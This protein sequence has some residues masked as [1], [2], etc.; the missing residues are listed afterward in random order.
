VKFVGVAASVFF[1]AAAPVILGVTQALAT[2]GAGAISHNS[3]EEID[4][5]KL[6]ELAQDGASE[7]Q[8]RKNSAKAL[9]EVWGKAKE[10]WKKITNS[11][12]A[13]WDEVADGEFSGENVKAFSQSSSGFISSV[14]ELLKG[15]GSP[16]GPQTVQIPEF[17][18]SDGRLS[19]IISNLTALRAEEATLRTNLAVLA[20]ELQQLQDQLITQTA[21]VS[22]LQKL[23]LKNNVDL[24]KLRQIS[25]DLRR[26]FL[27]S[28]ARTASLVLRGNVYHTGRHLEV[29]IG[30]LTFAGDQ[31]TRLQGELDMTDPHVLRNDLAAW[32]AEAW[33]NYSTLALSAEEALRAWSAA[34]GGATPTVYTYTADLDSASSSDY[35]RDGRDFL[36][37]IN[38]VLRESFNAENDEVKS[39]LARVPIRIPWEKSRVSNFI[40]PE[41]LLG[42]VVTRVEFDVPIDTSSGRQ[43][44]IFV[45]HPRNGELTYSS[46]GESCSLAQDYASNGTS[47]TFSASAPVD[48]DTP[49]NELEKLQTINAFTELKN[50]S[51]PIRASYYLTIDLPEPEAWEEAPIVRRMNISF[52]GIRKQ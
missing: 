50:R 39:G 18:A 8:K 35:W 51:Y 45:R 3:G 40:G 32:R 31:L 30:V 9:G 20:S 19:L 33:R 27:F 17:A 25:T 14:Q 7:Y 52:V 6:V 28:L 34:Q 49:G 22:E 44:L 29:D 36:S 11:F 1:P 16:T 42:V 12:D 4:F 43:V 24:L 47:Y 5:S 37:A 26:D 48:E 13:A 41:F 46:D 38:S 15:L 23:D 2:G 21:L 10:N